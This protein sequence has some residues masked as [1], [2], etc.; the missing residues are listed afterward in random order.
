MRFYNPRLAMITL[1]VSVAKGT[2]QVSMAKTL[3]PNFTGRPVKGQKVYDWDNT[4]YFSLSAG[5]C[6]NVLENLKAILDGSYVNTQ[7]KNEKFKRIFS[8][9]H[10]RDSQPSRL[11]IDRSKDQQGN[12]TGSIIMTILPPK[13][14]GSPITYAFRHNEML[15]FRFYIENGAKNLDYHKDLYE[16]ISRV[17]Y[18]KRNKSDG[19]RKSSYNSG[20]YDKSQG[21]SY[22]KGAQS[23][24]NK[25]AQSTLPSDSGAG[26]DAG[27][28]GDAFDA[29]INW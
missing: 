26:G 13:N 29:P 15:Q 14:E 1:G 22:N 9:T 7:E 10:Y 12:A 27:F 28:G 3:D 5:E 2:V 6:L 25:P 18:A 4:A 20:S 8:F 23:N 21:S 19:D 24:Y 16:A 11:L 17:E